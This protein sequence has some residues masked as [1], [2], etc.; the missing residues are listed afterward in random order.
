MSD[1]YG[2]LNSIK[3]FKEEISL[4]IAL[5][6]FLYIVY[7]IGRAGSFIAQV[8]FEPRDGW[9]PR[10]LDWLRGTGRVLLLTWYASTLAFAFPRRRFK[11]ARY[12]TELQI[13]LP[14]KTL[15]N[16]GDY[17]EREYKRRLKDVLDKEGERRA[18][19]RESL[20]ERLADDPGLLVAAL[21]WLLRKLGRMSGR[22]ERL[23]A[24]E[25][26]DFPQL[27]DGRTKI[28]RYFEALE[29]RSLDKDEDGTRFLTEAKF[30]S[31]YIAPIFLITGLVN[32]FA[33][34]DG[35]KLVLDNYRRLIDKDSYYSKELR[36]LRS[37]LF[38]C[39]LLWGPSIQP[40]SCE[41]WT[42][43]KHTYAL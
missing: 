17:N 9:F 2:V 25:I 31:G 10:T 6:T 38:N 1:L 15:P 27:D 7:G 23:G 20:R 28:K 12:Y 43:A 18:R 26:K 19:I 3:V 29:R 14:Q 40:C 33:D 13:L 41:Y 22:E 34:D 37:F 42:T 32:R 24:L 30:Q 4:V 8:V 39:W 21:Q 5:L 16:R 36:D 35:W 11:A